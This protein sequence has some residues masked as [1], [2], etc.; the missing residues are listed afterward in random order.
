MR[1]VFALMLASPAVLS[2]QVS[3]LQIEVNVGVALPVQELSGEEGFEGE[4]TSGATFGVHF[5]L[6]T[7]SYL[8]WYLGFSQHRFGCERGRCLT[9]DDI[10]STSWD[11]GARFNLVSGPVV[12]WLRVGVISHI[13]ELDR[14][15]DSP[16]GSTPTVVRLESDRG[17]GLEGGAGL[18]ITLGPR[19][20]LN[21]GVRY[22]R[23]TT[24]FGATGDLAMRFLAV[25]V[26]VV[27]GF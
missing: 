2:G 13:A 1:L 25:D 17:W 24:G 18:M 12:P 4:A 7:R 8:T 23:V 3:P 16:G 20:A 27:L 14:P 9:A 5:A 11:M 22:S 15:A 19:F 21:T 10:V 6:T 26:G